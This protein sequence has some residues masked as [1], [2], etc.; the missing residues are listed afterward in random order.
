MLATLLAAGAV[1]TA[2][3]FAVQDTTPFADPA[4]RELVERAMARHRSQDSL[5]RDYTARITYRLS[6]SLGRRRWAFPP[7]AAV[8][9]QT[10]RLQWA[11]P[12]DLRV[13]IEGTRFKA[14]NPNWRMESVFDSPWFVP[15]GLGDS[16]RVFGNDFPEVAA[17]HPFSAEAPR[18]YSY[19]LGDTVTITAGGRTLRLAA[20]AAT[21]RRAAPSL[22]SGRLWVDLESAEVVRFTFKYVGTGPW[23]APE[24]PT[25]RDTA[26]ARTANKWANRILSVDADLE[27]ALQE[28][29]YWMPYRQVLS[30]RVQIPIISDIVI[31]FDATTAFADYE[32]N[33]GTRVAFHLPPPDTTRGRLTRAEREARADTLRR[34]RRGASPDSNAARERTGVM[35]GGGR[36]EIR[37]PP[38]D[39]LRQYVG[40][41]DS[42]SLSRS[43]ADDAQLRE[44]QADMA[45]MAERL[46]RQITGIQTAG[47]AWERLSDLYRYNRVQ[48]SSLGAGYM[49]RLPSPDF[50]NLHGSARYGLGDGRFLARLAATRDAPEGRVSVSGYRDILDTDPFS[51]GLT[52]GNSMRAVFFAR[53][54]ADYLE[55]RGGSVSWDRPVGRTLDF[56][57]SARLEDQ[58]S[59][60]TQVHSGVN[61][62][63]GGTGSFLPNP[64]VLEGTI[65]T[66]AARLDGVAGRGTWWLTADAIMG[67][68]QTTGRFYGQV[69]Q[70]YGGW[71]GLELKGSAGVT[72]ADPAPQGELRAG[73]SAT[74][75]GFDYGAQRGPALW[76][77]Q[78]DLTPG[79]G[80]LKPVIFGDVGQAGVLGELSQQ[81]LLLGGGAGLSVLD[82]L[83]RAQVTYSFT[84]PD[85]DLRFEIA[86]GSLRL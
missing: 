70:R 5:V 27:Y 12:N 29:R 1:L 35:P 62:F 3:P 57:L 13:D 15:R 73:G 30:G 47:M 19:A 61:D 46:D 2:A 75:R 59:V 69:R 38:R 48:G 79:R 17:V 40:W 4:T 67:E 44:L 39:S 54:D 85:P 84:A 37:R 49:V 22:V 68:G 65:G 53:D 82:G 86:I 41:E 26:E 9:E 80:W 33:S 83:L 11:A 20:I 55:A 31:P 21:P 45:R 63:L 81:R 34:E 14:R 10:G 78:A 77:V 24:G 50:S 36:F 66:V 76:S 25:A 16:V 43:A 8:E 18:F 7:P 6:V 51:K 52:I 60:A 58:R 42:L 28:N 72:T 32:I 56:G 74:V 23:V 71:A 64:P